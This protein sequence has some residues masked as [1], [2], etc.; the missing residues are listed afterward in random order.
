MRKKLFVLIAALVLL[1]TAV[2]PTLAAPP[3]FG[4]LFYEGGTVRTIVPAAPL[5]EPGSD[6]LFVVTSGGVE[7]QLAIAGVAPGDPSYNGGK[8]A[9]HAVEWNDPADATLLTSEADV[10]EAEANGLVTVTRVEANDFKCPV[11][12]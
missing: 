9:F 10:L 6:N 4:T 1:I 8:W 2:A 7:G 5:N 3:A 11:Q 12:P